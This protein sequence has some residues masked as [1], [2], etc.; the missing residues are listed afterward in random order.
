V[1]RLRDDVFKLNYA[2]F[3]PAADGDG[4]A[5][6]LLKHADCQRA[7][8]LILRTVNSGKRRRILIYGD[9][10]CDG[11]TA[12]TLMR[13]LLVALNRSKNA[14]WPKTKIQ[15][16]IPH[17][18]RD[19]YGL[20][21]EVLARHFAGDKCR[22]DLLIV[23]DC[24]SN[25]PEEIHWLLNLKP[26][27]PVIV[28]DH[29]LPNLS[30][31]AAVPLVDDDFVHLNPKLWLDF[32]KRVPSSPRHKN[33]ESLVDL[34]ASG[35]VFLLAL[36]MRNENPA[37]DRERALLLAGLATCADVMKLTG[38]NRRLLIASLQLANQPAV[39]RRIPGLFQMV[40]RPA[41]KK[42][43]PDGPD[44]QALECEA[45]PWLDSL[46]N[47]YYSV[48]EETY[49]FEWGPCLNAPGRMGSAYE[50][51]NLLLLQGED[52]EKAR[53]AVR[54]CRKKNRWRQ[55]TQK[56]VE[57]AALEQA[58]QLFPDAKKAP[59]VILLCDPDWHP[60]VVGIVAARI[61][62]TYQRPAI[63]CTQT[64]AGN[65]KGSGRSVQVLHRVP[66]K[67]GE[68]FLQAMK[69]GTILKGGG[70]D[71][72]GGLEFTRAQRW[73]L[74][75]WFAKNAGL[76]DADSIEAAF[77]PRVE[78]YAYASVLSPSQWGE[79]FQKLR[80]FGNGNECPPL[81]VDRA[82]LVSLK[83]IPCVGYVP[84]WTQDDDPFVL[85]KFRQH[86]WV[87]R[88][89]AY[90]AWFLDLDT[91]CHFAAHWLD[92]EQAEYHWEVAQNFL[93]WRPWNRDRHSV[94]H[95]FKL[96]LELRA[97]I[98]RKQK[99]N[100][101]LGHKPE[102]EYSFQVKQC[103]P[104]ERQAYTPPPSQPTDAQGNSLLTLYPITD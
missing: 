70:H 42:A 93:N 65:W 11:V 51:L 3:D 67:M 69:D 96:E 43:G 100:I 5:N 31:P 80:P 17:R 28:I 8:E 30:N 63:V 89:W 60:G 78:A 85:K 97:H 35:L 92:L 9:F 87:D 25:N 21:K 101:M 12:T 76:E 58:R 83:P 77:K 23:V 62:E 81:L 55:V 91:H 84:D 29:H 22:P 13:D 1:Q 40:H 61:K 50:A 38:I 104:I 72:A 2:A 68:Q 18:I 37:W 33:A 102:W 49:G 66:F 94:H 79:F 16:L 54:Q 36:A 39:L 99:L 86:N 47:P 71:M 45:D 7:S 14:R 59:A 56:T 4:Q 75:R 46:L 103:I 74:Q 15:C 64:P 73:G 53:Q 20:N 19:G 48:T 90:A 98:P 27:I 32:E 82:R 95:D 24:G 26:K 52:F 10:D 88:L 41:P 57:K 6:P 44:E 34:C